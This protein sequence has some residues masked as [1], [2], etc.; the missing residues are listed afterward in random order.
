MRLLRKEDFC[1]SAHRRLYKERLG[2]VLGDIGAPKPPP[3]PV[4]GFLRLLQPHDG[5]PER[6]VCLEEFSAPPHPPHVRYDWPVAIPPAAGGDRKPAASAAP[7][8]PAA[9]VATR[10]S[11]RPLPPLAA[12]QA[13][14]FA[15]AADTGF[16]RLRELAGLLDTHAAG[17]APSLQPAPVARLVMAG[18]DPKPAHAPL[19]FPLFAVPLGDELERLREV[20]ALLDTHPAGAAPSLQPAPA[21]RLVM[22]GA[23]PKPAHAPLQFPLFAVPLGDEIERLRE[24]AGLLDSHPAGA[25]PSPQP[26]PA[27]RLVTSGAA[28][29]AAAA[30]PPAALPEFQCLAP[31]GAP[32]HS[33][34]W[35]TPLAMGQ[36]QDVPGEAVP[37]A[38]AAWMTSPPPAPVVRMVLPSMADSTAFGLPDPAMPHAMEP[39]QLGAALQLPACASWRPA[40]QPVAALVDAIPSLAADLALSAGVQLPGLPAWR[41]KDSLRGAHADPAMS[42]APERVETCPAADS[43]APVPALSTPRLSVPIPALVAISGRARLTCSSEPDVASRPALPAPAAA[44]AAAPAFGNTF[45]EARASADQPPIMGLAGDA[46]PTLPPAP[47]ATL[48]FH[49]RP[50]PGVVTKQLQWIAPEIAVS[51]PRL[52]VRPLF[53][54]WEDLAPRPAGPKFRFDK[55]AV[56]RRAVLQAATSKRARNTVGSIAAGLFLGTA[57][58][59]GTTSRQK[60]RENTTDIPVYETPA[61]AAPAQSA[62]RGAIARLRQAISDR[63]AASWSDTFRG[64][65]E[66]WGA[67]SKAW[68]PGWTHSPDGYVQPGTLAI[69]HP[70]VNYTDYKL[71][72]F[73]QI[74]RKSMDW[75]V[76]ARDARNYY[77]MKFTV[78]EPGLRPI[79]AMVHYAVVDGKKSRYSQTPLG[80]MVHNGRPM[81]VLVDVKGSR[82]TASVD[83]EEVGSW[84]DNALSTGGIGFFADAGEKARLYWMRVS[85]NEDVLGRICAYIAGSSNRQTAELWP[86]DRDGRPR[87]DGPDAPF[88]PAEAMSLA[89]VVIL[90]RSRMRSLAFRAAPHFTERRIETWKS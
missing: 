3:A 89:A 25:A 73:G 14:S 81:Q 11:V 52:T 28:L 61:A 47:F 54:R 43:R 63:A 2:R 8:V 57:L 9:A 29:E 27:A 72:F 40:P 38:S 78:V 37:P 19:Q 44:Q 45:S 50:K 90:R 42:P 30:V 31:I 33:P 82:F 67:G 39:T 41:A 35:A 34:Q 71:E 87:R 53:D 70:T 69:F 1:S 51:R 64:G 74:E 62:P 60:S 86:R 6:A 17:A 5:N 4:A 58:W 22:A 32:A 85:K 83:G 18:A 75:V 12:V 36:P 65:M 20:A 48:D 56:M 21:A 7:A 46:A 16:E 55:I 26:A 59:L 24:V 80:V 15:I 49:C 66:A 68:A 76:R 88:E 77:A 10:F 23:D 13:P 84:S 79:I